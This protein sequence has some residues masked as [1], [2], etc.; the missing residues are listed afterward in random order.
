MNR[1]RLLKLAPTALAATAVPAFPAATVA[2]DPII[3]LCDA[4][5]AAYQEWDAESEKDGGGDFDTPR[6]QK[7]DQLKEQL[8]ERIEA[9]P[10]TSDAGC[11]AFWRYVDADNYLRDQSMDFP[12][13]RRW[14]LMK[15]REWAEARALVA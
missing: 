7:L 5:V 13:V 14:Q 12:D 1:R 2:S 15:L 6:H 8:A 11:A 3:P 10:I 4:W 9:T